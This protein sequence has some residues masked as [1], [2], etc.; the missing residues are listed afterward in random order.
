M[1]LSLGNQR[2]ELTIDTNGAKIINFVARHGQVPIL[3]SCLHQSK[4]TPD[5]CGGFPL[6]PLCNRIRGNAYTLKGHTVSLPLTSPNHKE[7]LHGPGWMQEWQVLRQESAAAVLGFSYADGMSGYMFDAALQLMLTGKGLKITLSV[8]HQ[9]DRPR[10]YGLGFHPYFFIE[11]GT[12]LL[13]P[14]T[15]YF[16]EGPDQLSL[17]FTDSIPEQFDYSTCKDI[18]DCYVNH[19]YAGFHALRLFRPSGQTITLRSDQPYL[20]MYHVPGKNFIA[21]EPQSH[22]LDAVHKPGF[23]GLRL[24]SQPLNTMSTTLSIEYLP[25]P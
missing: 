6:L 14:A 21:L 13:L 3:Q 7:Y 8:Q 16:P 9:G 10:L 5:D 22:E 18:A 15:G 1:L 23:P 2:F 12:Q 24:L 17:P 11:P 19:C 25:V 20:M 4:Y